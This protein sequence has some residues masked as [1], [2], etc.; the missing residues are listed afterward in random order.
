MIH[1]MA[2]AAPGMSSV[3]TRSLISLS[4]FWVL[5]QSSSLCPDV[6]IHSSLLRPSP[7]LHIDSP[8]GETVIGR[9]G[10]YKEKCVR[11]LTRKAPTHL[12][13]FFTRFKSRLADATHHLNWVNLLCNFRKWRSILLKFSQMKYLFT[14]KMHY[15]NI[16]KWFQLR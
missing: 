2:S 14:F 1:T 7:G 12:D 13:L 9:P 3:I 15:L 5:I 8:G 6:L 16:Y 11:N 10:T 4:T